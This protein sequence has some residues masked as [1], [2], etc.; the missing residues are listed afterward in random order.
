M[1]MCRCVDV[2]MWTCGDG[3]VEIEM[4]RCGRGDV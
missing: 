4:W 3:D 1:W 2:D